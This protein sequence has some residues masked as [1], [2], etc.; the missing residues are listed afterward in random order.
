MP[1]SLTQLRKAYEILMERRQGVGLLAEGDQF[2]TFGEH[3]EQT[4]H[5]LSG[6]PLAHSW[7]Y[8]KAEPAL[9]FHRGDFDLVVRRLVVERARHVAVIER[10][11]PEPHNG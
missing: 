1:A 10:T 6:A 3:A 8:Y 7:S 5:D 9:C 4:L 11:E 2:W